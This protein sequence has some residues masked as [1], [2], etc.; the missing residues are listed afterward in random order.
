MKFGRPAAPGRVC[1]V[2]AMVEP[3]ADSTAPDGAPSDPV[4]DQPNLAPH[5]SHDRLRLNP[6]LAIEGLAVL[7]SPALVFF[8]LRLRAMAPID[9]PDPSMHTTF[10]VDPRDYYARYASAFSPT[11]RLREGARVGFLVPAR[12]SYLLF[13]AVPGFYVTRYAFALVAVVPVYVLLRRMYGRGAGALGVLVVLTSPVILTAWG[14]DYPDSAVVSYAAGALACL[15][16]PTQGRGRRAWI[17]A[18]G[19]LLTMAVWAHGIGALLAATTIV[20]YL[21]VRFLR[22]REHLLVDLAILA[23]TA[24]AVTG[25]LSLASELLLGHFDF[26]TPTW[27]A[28]LYLSQPSQEV[29]WHSSN[30]RWAPYVAYVLVPP[31]VAAAYAVVFGRKL[32]SVPTPQLF[33]GGVL[34][35]EVAVYFFMQFV[36]HL[37]TLE[38]HLFSSTLWAAVCIG[39]A[40]VLAEL[41]EPLFEHRLAQWLP[42]LV[43]SAVAAAGALA[44]EAGRHARVPAF[45]WA[46]YGFILALAI[47]AI[48]A[49]VAVVAHT[50]ALRKIK[51]PPAQWF[52]RLA[53]IAGVLGCALVLTAARVPAHRLLRGE[54][55]DPEPDYA[56]AIGGSWGNLVD[57]YRVTAELPLWVGPPAFQGEQLLTWWSRAQFGALVGP[58][59]IFHSGFTRVPSNPPKMTSFAESWLVDHHAKELLLLST[60]GNDFAADVTALAPFRPQVVK[61]GVLSS[62]TVHLHLELIVLGTSQVIV[63]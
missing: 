57:N 1:T 35:G 40:V 38:V 12:I 52:I 36:G 3:A 20:C 62:G 25:A 49:I 51:Q 61:E 19:V 26:I 32:R 2:L 10:I 17:V 41:A 29:L 50:R 4:S 56:G 8:A 23:G 34:V 13:G 43:V 18:A 60:T 24:V 16:M 44:M 39:L 54:V 6:A 14:T 37:Q 9:H 46:P 5:P 11:S 47:V 45:G 48:V 22:Q 63:S 28:F 59:G 55:S 27:R 42:A 21:V 15:A 30:P 53:A 31:A 58:V 7:L 33:V